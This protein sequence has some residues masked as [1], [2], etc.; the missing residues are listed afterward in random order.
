MS[1]DITASLS[2][3]TFEQVDEADRVRSV[4][5]SPSHTPLSG[6]GILYLAFI[7]SVIHP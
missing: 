7:Y 4:G 6:S 3:A 5:S 1:P 2:P